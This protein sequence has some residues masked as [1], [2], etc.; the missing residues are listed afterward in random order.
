[1]FFIVKRRYIYFTSYNISSV[2]Q[3]IILQEISRIYLQYTITYYVCILHSKPLINKFLS[4]IHLFYIPNFV[5]KY[6]TKKLDSLGYLQMLFQLVHL[7]SY[8][9]YWN[10]SASSHGLICKRLFL[11]DK[12][13]R[14]KFENY[15]Y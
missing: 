5:F 1:M 11:L 14:M 15:W 6:S 2:Y 4:G 10:N 12:K 3:I 13:Y 8:H 9:F 7:F